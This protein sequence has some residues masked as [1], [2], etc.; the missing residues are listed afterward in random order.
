MVCVASVEDVSVALVLK[1]LFLAIVG[2]TRHHLRLTFALE[3]IVRFCAI[4]YPGKDKLT[5]DLISSRVRVLV[6][7]LSPG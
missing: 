5:L 7:L 1:R 2:L 4:R 6:S 3:N